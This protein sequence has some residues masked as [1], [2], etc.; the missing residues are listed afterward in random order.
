[1]T[2][3]KSLFETQLSYHRHN[4][5]FHFASEISHL[6]KFFHKWHTQNTA[7]ATFD[8]MHASHPKLYSRSQF[9]RGTVQGGRSR[10]KMDGTRVLNWTVQRNKS[11]WSWMKPLF[12]LRTSW[13]SIPSTFEDRPLFLFCNAKVGGLCKW[14]VCESG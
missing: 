13:I 2:H 10:I 1:M 11:R 6:E 5:V 4:M 14:T 8:S 3:Y 7:C 12:N 9:S